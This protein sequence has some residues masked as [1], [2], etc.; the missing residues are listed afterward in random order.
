MARCIGVLRLGFARRALPHPT[1]AMF[2]HASVFQGFC[3]FVQP[4][5]EIVLDDARP[6]TFYLHEHVPPLDLRSTQEGDLMQFCQVCTHRT[7]RIAMLVITFFYGGFVGCGAEDSDSNDSSMGEPDTGPGVEPSP[8]PSPGPSPVA[9][10][11]DVRAECVAQVDRLSACGNID[12]ETAS[13]TREECGSANFSEGQVATVASCLGQWTCGGQ[14]PDCLGNPTPET[15]CDNLRPC[16]EGSTCQ[17]GVCQPE[18]GQCIEV[19]YS[20]GTV[21]DGTKQLRTGETCSFPGECLSEICVEASPEPGDV[22]TTENWCGNK[23]DCRTPQ[24]ADQECPGGFTCLN[25]Y[26]S[27]GDNPRWKCVRDRFAGSPIC[28]PD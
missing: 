4:A 3:L 11:R 21:G 23:G 24:N 12:P 15:E 5:F 26:N 8:G 14:P 13:L 9:E 7:L 27:L 28:P 25:I 20:A 16:F 22:T 6:A 1:T 2:P 18:G 17:Q 19:T 10:P